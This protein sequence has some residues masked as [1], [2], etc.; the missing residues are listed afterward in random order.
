M[1]AAGAFGV[2]GMDRAAVHGGNRIFDISALVER[3]GVDGHLHVET[4]GD[5]QRGADR[6]GSRTPV[7]VNLQAAGSGLDLLFERL[8]HRA[9]AFAQQAD[10]HR[11][12]LDRLQHAFDIPAA[13]SDGGAVTAVRRADSAAEQGRNAVAQAGV[14]L[15]RG[16]HVHMAVDAGRCQDQV[17]ARY[18]VGCGAGHQIRMHAVHD[19]GIARLADTGDF[20]VLDT[21]IGLH[22]AQIGVDDRHVGD[23][24]VERT[25][26][27]GHRI[28]QPH[29]VTDG[30]TAAVDDFVAV[31]AQVF[32]DL[33]VKIGVTQPDLVADG[34]TEKV[35]VFLT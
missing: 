9:V 22:D 6:S 13:G 15:L 26:L 32:F 16:D 27:R 28:G 11:K 14:G 25:L 21:H 20:S 8:V 12:S 19:I 31:F 17:F 29:A 18:G 24:E 3:I 5:A 30:F 2:V 35:V 10:V 34:R 33:D 23:N 1:S 7:L 4:I